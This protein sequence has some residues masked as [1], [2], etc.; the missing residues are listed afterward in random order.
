LKAMELGIAF[1]LQT[2]FR[3]E[4]VMYLSDPQRSLGGVPFQPNQLQASD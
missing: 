3:P 2:Q 1:Q 4:S